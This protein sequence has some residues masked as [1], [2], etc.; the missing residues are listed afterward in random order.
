[1]PSI[2]KV[3]YPLKV[4]ALLITVL[5]IDWDVKSIERET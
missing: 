4:V 1:M 5:A 3:F 2:A